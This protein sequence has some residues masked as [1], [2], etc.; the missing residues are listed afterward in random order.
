[1]PELILTRLHPGS[2]CLS[3]LHA[4]GWKGGSVSMPELPEVETMRGQLRPIE[5]S[6][7]VEVLQPTS[8]FRPIT[9]RPD[10]ARLRRILR[11]TRIAEVARLGKRLVLWTEKDSHMQA[12]VV[13]PR[14]TGCLTL[15]SPPDEEHVRLILRLSHPRF[16]KLYFWDSR[17]LGRVELVTPEQYSQLAKTLGPDALEVS[18]DYLRRKLGQSGRPIKLALMDQRVVA[19]IGNIYASEILF[20]AAIHPA[21]PSQNLAMGHWRKLARA[22]REVLQQAI[23]GKGSTLADGTYRAPD[24]QPGRYQFCHYVY[25]KDGQRCLRCKKEVIRRFPLGGRSTFF[26]PHCQKLL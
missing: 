26:C 14:M 24:G 7:I 17:G 19:G 5:G 12:L 18:A 21:S 20:A 13:E 22:M 10:F 1:M 15:S 9:L 8:R 3:G 4:V 16:P 6:K 11:D 2:L 23:K 25:Q